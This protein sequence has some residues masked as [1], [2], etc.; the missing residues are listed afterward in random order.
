M[1]ILTNS[2]VRLLYPAL[3][4]TD[5]AIFTPIHSDSSLPAFMST[6][7]KHTY[8]LATISF[9]IVSGPGP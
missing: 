4:G 5:R 6:I 1:I 9:K 8:R 7:D 3:P 2:Q